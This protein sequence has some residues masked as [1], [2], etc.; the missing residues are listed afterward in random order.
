MVTFIK[1]EK[2][3]Q[4]EEGRMCKRKSASVYVC[5]LEV[6][7]EITNDIQIFYINVHEH[8]F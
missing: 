2:Y 6:F 5:H 7:S 4:E 1:Q 8:L 3:T